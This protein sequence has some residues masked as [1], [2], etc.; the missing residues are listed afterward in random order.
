MKVAV[1]GAV[2][3]CHLV[4]FVQVGVTNTY[5]LFLCGESGNHRM[6]RELDEVNT[7][8]LGKYLSDFHVLFRLRQFGG[9]LGFSG[10]L[11]S[12]LHSGILD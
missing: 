2:M 12:S 6:R 10:D 5:A 1:N 4:V 8:A 7:P 3:E 11:R 9:K